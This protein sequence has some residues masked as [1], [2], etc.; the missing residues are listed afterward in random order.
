MILRD[1]GLLWE[2]RKCLKAVEVSQ[3]LR[4]LDVEGVDEVALEG[5]RDSLGVLL[6]QRLQVGNRLV[7][8]LNRQLLRVLTFP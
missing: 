4:I 5:L 2:V 8:M 1:D 3:L 7:N 6:T